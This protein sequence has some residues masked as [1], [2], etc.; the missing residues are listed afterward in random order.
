MVCVCH[1]GPV[2]ITDPTLARELL[3]RAE[4]LASAG[5]S[6]LVRGMVDAWQLVSA[7]TAD[8]H[9]VHIIPGDTVRFGGRNSIGWIAASETGVLA[10]ALAERPHAARELIGSFSPLDPGGAISG[11]GFEVAVEA[12]AGDPATAR[13]IAKSLITE[14][15]RRSDV[16]WHGE[17]AVLLGICRLREDDPL[18]ALRYLAAGRH[19]PMRW[20]SWYTIA[21]RFSRRAQAGLDP[22]DVMT[23][24]SAGRSQSVEPILDIELR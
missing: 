10:H 4:H 19:S 2:M 15:D 12:M 21:R 5:T 11:R 13:R 22:T 23:A 18:T 6:A 9:N 24:I 1:A 20:P 16:L 8:P 14:V 17:L 3:A 7:F